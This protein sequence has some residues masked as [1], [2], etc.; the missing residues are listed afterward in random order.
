LLKSPEQAVPKYFPIDAGVSFDCSLSDIVVIS[1]TEENLSADFVLP[2]TEGRALRIRF[3]K[4]TI[5]RLLG[6]LALSTENDT[7]DEGTIPLHFA[8]LVE[9]SA[10]EKAQ[11]E[12][13]KMVHEPVHHY[14]FVTGGGCMDVLSKAE[15]SFDVVEIS[16]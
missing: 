1:W 13:W 9:G 11:S 10:F 3:N 8:Y 4:E 16:K 7:K 2:R 12:A 6:E 5:V 15:P 14:R